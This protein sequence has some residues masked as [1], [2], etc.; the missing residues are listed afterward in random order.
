MSLED[1]FIAIV[2]QTSSQKPR[3]ERRGARRPAREGAEQQMAKQIIQKTEKSDGKP[4]GELSALF[5]EDEEEK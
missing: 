2:D 5:G 4:E 1:I 3:Y